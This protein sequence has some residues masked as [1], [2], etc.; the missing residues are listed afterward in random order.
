MIKLPYA[1][2]FPWRFDTRSAFKLV[3]CSPSLSKTLSLHNAGFLSAFKSVPKAIAE[4]DCSFFHNVMEP[5]LA[6]AM[7]EGLGVIKRR[8]NE[9]RLI[10]EG[11][12]V[13]SYFYNEKLYVGVDIV[14]D[15]NSKKLECF[16]LT[17]LFGF[18]RWSNDGRVPVVNVK[19][20]YETLSLLKPK[21]ILK[22]DVLYSSPMKLV[23]F[24]ETGECL[25]GQK[26]YMPETHKLRFESMLSF[27]DTTMGK[28]HAIRELVKFARAGDSSL[29]KEAD[30]LIT[31][32]DDYLK[33]NPFVVAS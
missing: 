32:V 16:G 2:S 30:W 19:L 11:E 27:P 14:R 18:I 6:K 15:N 3:P 20:F 22:V 29:L 10:N 13:A 28:V 1:L 33:G 24:D 4:G 21:V 31:D 23:L 7:D 26:N 25:K 12:Y 17:D 5:R 9:L 8:N